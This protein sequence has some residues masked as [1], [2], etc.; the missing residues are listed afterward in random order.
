[1]A[2]LFFRSEIHT[3]ETM[4]GLSLPNQNRILETAMAPLFRNHVI[5]DNGC[6]GF[7]SKYGIWALMTGLCLP[8]QSSNLRMDGWILLPFRN[9]ISIIAMAGLLLRSEIRSSAVS[10]VASFFPL[11]SDFGLCDVSSF[12]KVQGK[13]DH[14]SSGFFSKYNT[15]ASDSWSLLSFLKLAAV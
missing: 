9:T 15:S 1:M 3:T 8:Y 13:D 10:C 7:F 6:S 12:L 11:K 5:L 14:G 2:A 4:C